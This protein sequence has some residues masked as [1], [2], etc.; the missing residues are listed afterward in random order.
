MAARFRLV[1]YHNL[2]TDDQVSIETLTGQ[3]GVPRGPPVFLWV[4]PSLKIS[5]NVAIEN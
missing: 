2:P 4:K 1:K 3:S 5:Y